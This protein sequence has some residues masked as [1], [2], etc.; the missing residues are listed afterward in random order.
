[1]MNQG[2]DVATCHNCGAGVSI[3]N[4]GLFGK[5]SWL[6]RLLG[7]KQTVTHWWCDKCGSVTVIAPVVF[8]PDNIE[9][10]MYHIKQR[11]EIRE[12]EIESM[13]FLERFK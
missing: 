10:F 13:R 8:T 9:M 5:P 2:N 4:V 3:Y 11:R 6:D 7:T 12:K 1:M